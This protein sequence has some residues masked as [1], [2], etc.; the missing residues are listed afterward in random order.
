MIRRTPWRYPF[1]LG[2][3][4]LLLVT[5]CAPTAA[6]PAPTQ[7][8]AAAAP[9]AKPAAPAPA[10]PAA[11]PTTAPAAKAP[12]APAAAPKS[13]TRL[14]I[15]Y[16]AE[17]VNMVPYFAQTS[18]EPVIW[19]SVMEPLVDWDEKSSEHRRGVLATSWEAPD[20]T[21]WVFR[22]QQGVKFHDGSPLRPEDVVHS[23]DRAKNDA[24]S[25]RKPSVSNVERVEPLGEDAVKITL[26]QPDAVFL[27]R[28]KNIYITSKAVWDQFGPEE[29]D[30]KAIGTGPYTF[31]SHVPGQGTVLEK[32]PN[33]WANLP[34][35]ADTVIYRGI[36]ENEPRVT[37]LL[38][39]EVDIISEVSPD[40]APRIDSSSRTQ[41]VGVRGQRIMF[42]QMNPAHAPWDNKALRKAV[43]HAIDKQGLI[44]GLLGGRGY[45]LQIPIGENVYGYNAEAVNP[46]YEYNPEKAKQLL[47]EAGYPNGLDVEL[48]PTIGNNLKDYEIAQAMGAMLTQVGIRTEVKNIEWSTLWPQIQENKIPFYFMGRGSVD[49]PSEYL[50][51]YFRFGVTKRT[52][53]S[54]PRVDEL[55]IAES[56]EYDDTKRKQLLAQAMS[57]IMDDAPATFLFNYED[58][59]GVARNLEWT[60]R[61]DELIRAAEVKLK[62]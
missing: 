19:G 35:L 6:P 10:A 41:T 2:L 20:K 22:L 1:S 47:A 17:I 61:S 53:Y 31:K 44:N 37:A 48:F 24:K 8:P 26:K 13:P 15:A 3:V 12:A 42:L 40:M 51:Q 23:F 14:T 50:S 52:S 56:Q 57:I 34:N 28:L 9:A 16:T 30:K 11:A 29:A 18:A 7:A 5:A 43:S 60:P 4:A 25:T 21:T 45:P 32:N 36:K 54:N 49:D 33:H 39:G 27:S 58:T 46:K 59:Y 38:N 62:S 55:L